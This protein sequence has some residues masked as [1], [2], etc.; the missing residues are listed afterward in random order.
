[1]TYVRFV[2]VVERQSMNCLAN[3]PISF[4]S[5]IAHAIATAMYRV[6]KSSDVCLQNSCIS[7]EAIW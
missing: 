6:M 4:T 1:M 2:H 3:L 7:L 5:S